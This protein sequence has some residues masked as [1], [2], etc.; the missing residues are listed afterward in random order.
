VAL[1]NAQSSG[2]PPAKAND[3]PRHGWLSFSTRALLA[4]L[5]VVLAVVAY[6]PAQLHGKPFPRV[7]GDASLYAYQ[8]MRAAECHGQWWHIVKDARLGHP[9][10]TE[11]AKHPGL[12]EGVDL[13]LLAALTGGS[14]GTTATYHLAVL[15]ALLVNGWITAF[16][17]LRFTRSAL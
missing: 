6:Y 16:I 9:Y 8:L 15:A 11:F 10:P 4:V 1:E 3:T 13:M 17:V 5:P 7:Q 14:L 12:F 2:S